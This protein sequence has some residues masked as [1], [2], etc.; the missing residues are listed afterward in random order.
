MD[1]G[2]N[3]RLEADKIL[4]TMFNKETEDGVPVEDAVYNMFNKKEKQVVFTP[5]GTASSFT[6]PS[7]HLPA[8]YEL[9]A[10][11]AKKQQ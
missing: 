4:E 2:I 8:F 7:Y 3:Y 10:R 1:P 6:D 5:Y 9:W 11:W